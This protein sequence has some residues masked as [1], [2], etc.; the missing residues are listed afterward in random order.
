AS[1]LIRPSVIWIRAARPQHLP[2]GLNTP[3]RPPLARPSLSLSFP[4]LV[5]APPSSTT[6]IALPPPSHTLRPSPPLPAPP[7]PAILHPP[8][9]CLIASVAL[10]LHPPSTRN[11]GGSSQLT[12]PLLTAPITR[13]NGSREEGRREAPGHH[14]LHRC[15]QLRSHPRLDAIQTLSSAYIKHT[16]AILGEHG[17]G[18]DV[19]SALSRLGDNPLLGGMTSLQ[20]AVTPA[21]PISAAA[22]EAL[23]KERKKR[24]H[25]PNAPKRPLTP[26]FLYMQ[27]ARPIIAGDLGPDAAKGAVSEEGTRRW[28]TMSAADKQL[29]HSAYKDNLRLYNARMH[30]Y[31]AGNQDAKD[32]SDAAAAAYAEEHNI[33]AEATADAQLA[34]EANA[35]NLAAAAAEEEEAQADEP[36]PKTPKGKRASTAAK[37]KSGGP[38]AAPAAIVPPASGKGAA[39]PSAKETPATDK[40]RKRGKAD[41]AEKE[42]TPKTG[43]KSGKPSRKKKSKSD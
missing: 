28:G 22:A 35:S 31:R 33:G 26:Y 37:A 6:P 14:S 34:E 43:D 5:F 18:L 27:T 2:Q 16:N 30:S 40:K 17:A 21:A 1:D 23:K 42:E 8:P 9:P 20:R 4:S 32:M 12:L 38:N 7:R 29:W 15:R 10:L 25:D 36:A 39:T 41:A 13:H 3:E 19:E 24:Q 11:H